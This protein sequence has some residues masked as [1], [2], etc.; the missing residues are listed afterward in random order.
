MVNKDYILRLAERF[1]RE[2]AMLLHLRQRN[3]H[4]EALINID[5]LFLQSVG[6]TTHFINSASEEMLLKMISPLETLNLEKC[7][8]IAVLLKEE[9]DIYAEIGKPDESYYRHIKALFFFLE[10]ALHEK[11]SKDLNVPAAIED[12]LQKLEE[13]E[14]SM[15]MKSKLFRYFE[16]TGSYSKAED[17]LFELVESDEPSTQQT[18]STGIDFYQRLLRKSDTDLQLGGLTRQEVEAGLEHVA[19]L[20]N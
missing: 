2:L 8:W 10:A 14:L 1:G 19:N 5:E 20:D 16:M 7:L 6:L 9:G 18:V 13:F 4:E 12:L 11:Q 17:I 3:Q 15:D